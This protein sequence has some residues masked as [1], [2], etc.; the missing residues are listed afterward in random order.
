MEEEVDGDGDDDSD[1]FGDLNERSWERM[2]FAMPRDLKE[3]DG[4]RDSSFRRTL[5]SGVSYWYLLYVYQGCSRGC[6]I[7]MQVCFF[8]HR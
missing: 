4:W 1:E 8:S 7:G 2:K 6:L 3:P 5:L